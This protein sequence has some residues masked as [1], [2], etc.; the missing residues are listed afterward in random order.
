MNSYTTVVW[1]LALPVSAPM[2][3]HHPDQDFRFLLC[4]S[5]LIFSDWTNAGC[6]LRAGFKVVFETR[7]VLCLPIL[8]LRLAPEL[9]ASPVRSDLG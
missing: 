7:L 5:L 9:F 6:H 4:C 1:A 3:A 2:V 8:L